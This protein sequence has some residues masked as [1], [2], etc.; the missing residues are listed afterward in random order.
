MTTGGGKSYYYL[1]DA[2]GNVLGLVDDSGKRTHI[3]AYAP[4]GPPRG[5]TAE[6]VP[7]AVPLRRRLR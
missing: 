7:P 1:T 3:Y 6:A 2:T 4:T 5:T